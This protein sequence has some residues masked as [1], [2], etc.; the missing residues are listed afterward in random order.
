ML[1]QLVLHKAKSAETYNTHLWIRAGLQ[2]GLDLGNTLIT[3]LGEQP[4][5]ACLDIG[6]RVSKQR[7]DRG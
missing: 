1:E 6:V 4:D 3:E 2:Q 7:L 5:S